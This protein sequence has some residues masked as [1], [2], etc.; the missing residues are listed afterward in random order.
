MITKDVVTETSKQSFLKKLELSS[1]TYDY[2]DP[3]KNVKE[4]KEKLKAIQRVQQMFSD[5]K[6]VKLLI[7]PH[8]N[9]V[10]EMISAN[11]FRPLPCLSKADLEKEDTGID[12]EDTKDPAW[13]YL[14]AI[15][16]LFYDMVSCELID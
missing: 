4:K 1:K 16:E 10:I 6:Y 7:I 11:I 12:A 2:K 9:K 3:T 5:E 15:Y 8:L 13:P 14:Q